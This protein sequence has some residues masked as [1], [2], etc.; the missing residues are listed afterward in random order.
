[1]HVREACEMESFDNETSP[2]A[3]L[4]RHAKYI[5]MLPCYPTE[6]SFDAPPFLK[7]PL[8]TSTYRITSAS[9]ALPAQPMPE[10]SSVDGW[11]RSV[12]P[13]YP[14]AEPLAPLK[15]PAAAAVLQAG[16]LPG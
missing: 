13:P 9:S 4:A 5:L 8:E 14:P 3:R 2:P 10:L 15:L 16:A 1:M 12:H 6:S 7:P 11:I